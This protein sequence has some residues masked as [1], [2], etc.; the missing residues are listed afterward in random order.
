MASRKKRGPS[1][2]LQ[3]RRK[4]SLRQLREVEILSRMKVPDGT[5]NERDIRHV[6]SICQTDASG[7]AVQTGAGMGPWRHV[8]RA[9]ILSPLAN[10][11]CSGAMPLA[12]NS[13][14]TR[15]EARRAFSSGYAE[16]AV[17]RGLQ[18]FGDLF[19]REVA[20]SAPA[21]GRASVRIQGEGS[22]QAA[23]EFSSEIPLGGAVEQIPF[24][25]RAE[26]GD[27][28]LHFPAMLAVSRGVDQYVEAV[29]ERPFAGV[30]VGVSGLVAA[31]PA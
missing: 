15:L 2:A 30:P 10:G 7:D 3:N 27:E 4:C 22:K 8:S 16:R 18:I 5:Y 26:P 6:S 1:L 13:S 31:F 11:P 29:D 9:W 25:L 12:D 20:E 21:T 23:P 17:S 28:F 14:C 24:G 19:P